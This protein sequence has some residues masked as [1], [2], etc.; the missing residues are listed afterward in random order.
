MG[1]MDGISG[2][3]T[4]IIPMMIGGGMIKVF[5]M[6]ANMVGI[7]PETSSTYQILY[8]LGDA[9]IYFFPVF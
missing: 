5:Y 7:L 1:I 4:P 6:L 9:F 3:I 8:W 2:C